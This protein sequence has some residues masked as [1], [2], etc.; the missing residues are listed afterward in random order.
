[1]S[2]S[3]ERNLMETMPTHDIKNIHNN[4]GA[5]LIDKKCP[6]SPDSPRIP[7]TDIYI[8]CS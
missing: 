1:M 2:V 5:I 3:R 7:E 4:N 6:I 8:F